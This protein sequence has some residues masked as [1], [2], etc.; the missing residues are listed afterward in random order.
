MLAQ[1]CLDRRPFD[2]AI[3]HMQRR[4]ELNPNNQWNVADMGLVLTY[5]GRAEEA[6]VWYGA[7]PADRS[8]LRPAL[9]LATDGTT[10]AWSSA[11]TRRPIDPVRS[12]P[13]LSGTAAPR[14]MAGCQ[15]GS[16][17]WSARRP[18]WPNACRCGRIS[19][20]GNGC[21]RNRTGSRPTPNESPSHCASPAC[22]IHPNRR[23]SGTVLDFWFQEIGARH[24][25]SKSAE[26]DA[27]IR[28]TIPGAV[29]TARERAMQRYRR[30]ATAA[31]RG[32]RARPVLAEHV[33]RLAARVR[34]RS[35]RTPA[36]AADHRTGIRLRPHERGTTLSLPALRAQRGSRGPG[37]LMRT[38]RAPRQRR[39]DAVRPG[40]QGHHRPVR[41]LPASQCRARPDLD[42]G[43]DRAAG[44]TDGI[45][46][47]PPPLSTPPPPLSPPSPFLPSPP[48]HRHGDGGP[49]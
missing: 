17:T 49:P 1:V 31:C 46:L 6:L 23:G 38:D 37:A 13:G 5:I 36:G 18:A 2:L 3:E 28:G 25:F 21:R 24:W 4:V 20:S 42:G 15:R 33:P 11:G 7:G 45:V 19:R 40:A 30:P 43:G 48:P 32:G 14:C 22:P 12:P 16:A 27:E 39:L 34:R 41:P 26:I 44:G 47:H 8:V 10:R 29:R 9:V 35:A